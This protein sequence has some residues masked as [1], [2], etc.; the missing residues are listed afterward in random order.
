[1]KNW[2]CKSDTGNKMRT[3]RFEISAFT[4]IDIHAEDLNEARKL[5]DKEWHEIFQNGLFGNIE[6]VEE[7]K[8]EKTKYQIEWERHKNQHKDDDY[9]ADEACR[10]DG[11]GF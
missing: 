7:I 10:W 1:M 11:Q 9:D 5:A 3:F 4:E 2:Q 8:E 6:F